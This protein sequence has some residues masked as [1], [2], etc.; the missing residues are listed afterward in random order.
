[1]R[2]YS[3]FS[4]LEVKRDSEA[5]KRRSGPALRPCGMILAEY[6]EVSVI[7]AY[8]DKERGTW[9]ASFYYTDWQGHRKLKK[10]RGFARQKDAKAFEDEFLKTRAQ[11]C[12]MTFGSMVELY[13]D[14]MEH[15]LKANT[16]RNKRYLY[17]ARI[18]PF[19]QDLKINDITPAHVR[20][21]QSNLLAEGVAPTYAKTINNQLSAVFN[22]ACQYYG[23]SLIHI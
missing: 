6:R 10:K 12:D 18:L 11:S 16:M 15:R 5:T 23:L 13:L 1:M 14:D 19:F 20:K 7:P 17:K 21:W 22:Y 4:V 9:Y 3:A 8:K 2:A